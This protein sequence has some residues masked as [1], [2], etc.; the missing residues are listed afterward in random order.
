MAGD[1]VDEFS[2]TVR[3]NNGVLA[4]SATGTVETDNYDTGNDFSLAG[5][6]SLNPAATIQE[7]TVTKIG[8]KSLELVL[9]TTGGNAI[10]YPH[11]G[12][13]FVHDKLQIDSVE[14]NDPNATGATVEG[15]WVGE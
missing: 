7:L 5:G 1:G 3:G 2:Q 15:V 10:N 4:T 13:T 12:G 6:D 11:Q 9:H 8:D 14:V